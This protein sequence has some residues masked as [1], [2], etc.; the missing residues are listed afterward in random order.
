MPAPDPR[1][2]TEPSADLRQLAS[3]Y[4]QM[5]IALTQEG[6]TEQQALLI[7]GQ[8][9]AASFLAGGGDDS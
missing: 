4:H 8:N 9:I 1:P 3:I 2:P 5:F 7:I 6:F